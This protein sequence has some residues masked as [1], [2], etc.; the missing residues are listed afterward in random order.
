[1]IDLVNVY[2]FIVL[3]TINLLIHCFFCFLQYIFHTCSTRQEKINALTDKLNFDAPRNIRSLT[4]KF[5]VIFC[6][7]QKT[8]SQRAS[9][10]LIVLDHKLNIE[11]E[12]KN[13]FVKM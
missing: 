3:T 1:M 10:R 13:L 9:L 12:Q 4:I 5:I 8:V 11:S 2:A 7:R 6:L